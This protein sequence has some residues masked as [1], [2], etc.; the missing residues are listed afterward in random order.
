MNY[1]LSLVF[2]SLVVCKAQPRVR[3]EV[4]S[5]LNLQQLAWNEGRIEEFMQYY[6]NHDSLRFVSGKG[7]TLGWQATLQNYQKKYFNRALMGTLAFTIVHWEILNSKTCMVSGIW[8]LTRD[9]P[10]GGRFTLLWKKIKG[11]W[12]IVYDH[13]S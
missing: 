6:W 13:T 2:L 10:L 1:I 9:Q 12:K 8:Q 11:N 3:L 7:M 4:Q 5:A